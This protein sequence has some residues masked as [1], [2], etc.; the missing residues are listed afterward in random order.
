[1][2]TI[3]DKIDLDVFKQTLEKIQSLSP[4]YWED[5]LQS[6]QE[7]II[8]VSESEIKK[9]IDKSAQLYHLDE[10]Q[11]L[12]R[13]DQFRGISTYNKHANGKEGYDFT[14]TY[15]FFGNTETLSYIGSITDKEYMASMPDQGKKYIQR[16]VLNTLSPE[17]VKEECLTNGIKQPCYWA[18]AY[19]KFVISNVD[20]SLALDLIQN[21]ILTSK[22]S[23]N[24]FLSRVT[25][26][27]NQ[28]FNISKD[29]YKTAKQCAEITSIDNKTLQKPNWK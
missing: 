5:V 17:T 19:D 6:F 3:L 13:E 29:L 25:I 14:G 9:L 10:R 22:Q 11:V 24:D 7:C 2:A 1:M 26:L 21:G 8:D 23:N 27:Q 28:L 16:F 20:I 18:T 12:I 4:E 15:D